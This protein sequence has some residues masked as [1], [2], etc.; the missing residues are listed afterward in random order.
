M[1]A[2]ATFGW[3]SATL[4]QRVTQPVNRPRPGRP[5]LRPGRLDPG[6]VNYGSVAGVFTVVSVNARD[7]KLRLRDDGG[8]TADAYVS[9]RL[10]D[11]ESLSAGDVVA[12]DFFVQDGNEDRLEIASIEKLE[13]ASR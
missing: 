3:A 13:P 4:A 8:N 1:L 6:G 12:V 7:N 9:E 11:V 10:F 5:P 2:T